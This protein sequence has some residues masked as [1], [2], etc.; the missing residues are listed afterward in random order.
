MMR[1]LPTYECIMS[2]FQFDFA[3]V[4]WG[5]KPD[6]IIEMLNNSVIAGG[7]QKETK[8]AMSD[9]EIVAALKSPK[10]SMTRCVVE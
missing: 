1:H 5:M 4:T 8:V 2:P 7:R 6:L 3:S 10:R 9:R